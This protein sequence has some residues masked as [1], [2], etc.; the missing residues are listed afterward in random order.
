VCRH[1]QIHV[2]DHNDFVDVAE[3]VDGNAIELR[4]GE[5]S[6]VV[7]AT[8]DRLHCSSTCIDDSLTQTEAKLRHSGLIIRRSTVC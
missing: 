6:D 3:D 4:G 2:D 8:N 1:D 7:D 5:D